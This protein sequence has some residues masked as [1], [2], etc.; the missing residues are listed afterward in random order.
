[1][2]TDSQAGNKQGIWRSAVALGLVA[3]VGTGLLVF[4][5]A[6]T[7][8]RIADQ[9]S[10]AAIKQ[11]R[12][13][14]NPRLFDN[15]L[16]NDQII[17]ADSGWFSQGQA[18]TIYRAR[19][20]SEPVAAIFK[21]FTEDGYNGKIHLLI[22]ILADGSIS[23]VR[24]ISHKETPGLGD[25]IEIRKSDWIRGFTGKS[26]H[27]DSEQKWAVKKD[28]GQFDQF[29]GATITPR[30]IVQMINKTLEYFKLNQ[31]HIFSRTTVQQDSQ[32]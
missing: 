15:D 24:V 32:E 11:L 9:Q 5:E 21:L 1:M 28:G 6:L 25:A 7:R 27:Q 23:G 12:Q 13:V 30:A 17:I 3:I 31:E 4:V 8:P 19:K 26:L 18:V 10:L 16:Q 29:T 2:D 22:G 20:G 14:I